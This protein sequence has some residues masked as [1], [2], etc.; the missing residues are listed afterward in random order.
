MER[1]IH[2]VTQHRKELEK[3]VVTGGISIDQ[4]DTQIDIGNE[5]EIGGV[6]RE[7]VTGMFIS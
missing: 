4:T 3:V 7:I 1:S 5:I 6:V 2:L